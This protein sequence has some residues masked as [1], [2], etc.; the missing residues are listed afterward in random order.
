MNTSSLSWCLTMMG[1]EI[2]GMAIIQRNTWK[3][4]KNMPKL[5]WWATFPVFPHSLKN[6]HFARSLTKQ[7]CFSSLR[8]I[9]K[10]WHFY[11]RRGWSDG[12]VKLK[13]ANHIGCSFFLLDSYIV[14]LLPNW[15]CRRYWKHE[16]GLVSKAFGILR[17]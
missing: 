7:L 2:G 10:W 4:W 12:I 13:C 9:W 6:V 16:N 15:G 3:L 11:Y 8:A 14:F 5:I 1:R 17:L